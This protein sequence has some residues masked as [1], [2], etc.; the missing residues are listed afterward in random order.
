MSSQPLSSTPGS[1]PA[2]IRR[3][4]FLLVSCLALVFLAPHAARAQTDTALTT[5]NGAWHDNGVWVIGTSEDQRAIGVQIQSTTGGESF[6]G[7]M[8]YAGEGPIGFRAD[9]AG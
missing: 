4:L 6:T 5:G 1:A 8:K 7:T 9:R 3:R 2:A